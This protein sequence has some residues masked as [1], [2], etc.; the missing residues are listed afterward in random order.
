MSTSADGSMILWNPQTAGA[1]LKMSSEDGRY[2]QGAITSLAIHK[3][4]QLVLTGAEDGTLRLSHLIQGKILASFVNHED[5]IE[6][7]AFSDQ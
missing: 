2:H 5:S 6:G 7:L 4:N 1:I 3:D